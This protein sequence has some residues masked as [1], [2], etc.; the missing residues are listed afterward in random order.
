MSG[1]HIL[2]SAIGRFFVVIRRLARDA[3]LQIL[4]QDL[5][6]APTHPARPAHRR[7]SALGLVSPITFETRLLA[8]QAA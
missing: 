6:R 3:P 8:A 1:R 4:E 7:H 2:G 5:A